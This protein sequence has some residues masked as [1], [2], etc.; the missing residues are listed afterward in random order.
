MSIVA[1]PFVANS[2]ALESVVAETIVLRSIVSGSNVT[3]L[4]GA[5]SIIP[6]SIVCWKLNLRSL[7]I[8]LFQGP[9]LRVHFCG[10]ISEGSIV[11]VTNV[12]VFIVARSF[13]AW[14]PLRDALLGSF[15][16]CPLLRSP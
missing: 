2:I 16:Q 7:L 5:R 14:L 10:S 3:E 11:A 13:A 6:W 1:E 9:M 12:T 8:S 4:I 15:V